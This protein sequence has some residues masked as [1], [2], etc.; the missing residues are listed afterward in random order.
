MTAAEP[1]QHEVKTSTHT[2]RGHTMN[3]PALTPTADS[4]KL[5][6]NE[7]GI[8]TGGLAAIAVNRV[9]TGQDETMIEVVI[10]EMNGV[11]IVRA[12]ITRPRRTKV[13]ATTILQHAQ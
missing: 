9:A 8:Q 10:M 6:W 7:A 1:Q 12:E 4:E 3:E 2:T 5:T 11:I 13:T